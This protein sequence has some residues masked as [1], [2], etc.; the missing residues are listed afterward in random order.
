[1]CTN[2]NYPMHKPGLLICFLL[3]SLLSFGQNQVRK[4]APKIFID[5]QT[6]CQMTFLKQELSYVNHMLDRQN[7]D[8]FI[9]ITS[10]ETGSGGDQYQ[11][12]LKGQE[13]FE[14]IIDTVVYNVE[15][16]IGENVQRTEMLVNLEKGLLPY[17]VKTS[18][19]DDIEFKIKKPEA[20]VE[21]IKDP[22]NSWVFNTRCNVNLNGQQVSKYT[23]LFGR[24]SAAK[25]T[26]EVKIEPRIFYSLNRS[27][28]SFE[29]EEDEIYNITSSGANLTYV[30]SVSPNFSAG[31]FTE[32]TESSFSNYQLSFSFQP[33]VEYNFYP[34][35]EANKRQ[36]SLL[37]RV[38][39]Q[40]NNYVDS[41]I[42]NT[43]KEWLLR[44]S[45]EMNFTKVEDWGSMDVEITFGNYLHDWNLLFTR[46]EPWIEL[47]IVKGLRL[48]IGGSFSWIRNQVNLPKGDASREDVL[49]QLQQLQSNYNYYGWMGINYRFGSTYNNIV[50]VRF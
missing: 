11:I 47:N 6:W 25:V 9:Q 22:W 26:D 34:Y 7:A 32:L 23:N 48:N 20:K 36:F 44:H 46:I 12:E 31:F 35:A 3:L 27:K 10:L 37:Y 40:F 18:L 5:C 43:E 19:A 33:A 50:N 24:I 16:N 38:G 30:K 28:F 45:M 39:P 2:Y 17:L 1:M 42:F 13:R 41:T 8:V 15:P 29:E 21:A 4:D 14:G 49:L